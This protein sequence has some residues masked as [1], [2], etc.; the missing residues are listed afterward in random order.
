MPWYQGNTVLYSLENTHIGG[1]RNLIEARFPIQKVI[2]PHHPDFPD[3]RGFA[4][5]IEGGVFNP[6]DEVLLL[7]S[8]L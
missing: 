2:R 6:G 1:D 8:E 3:F 7:P 4:G 5:R